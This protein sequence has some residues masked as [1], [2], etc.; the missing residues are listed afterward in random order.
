MFI[1]AKL[2][3]SQLVNIV[4]GTVCAVAILCALMLKLVSTIRNRKLDA[5]ADRKY[6]EW[7]ADVEANGGKLPVRTPPIR[8]D[9]GETCRFM[10][11]TARLYEPRA[12]SSGRYGGGSIHIDQGVSIHTGRITTESH[13]E[14]RVT[15]RGALYVTDKRIIFNG[16]IADHIVPLRDILSVRAGYRDACVHL[17]TSSK[18]VAFGSI[19]GQIFAAVVNSLC[20]SN[21]QVPGA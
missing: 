13:D 21:E 18:P 8:L 17:Q 14:W 4:G 3:D 16:E 19:N 20:S 2:T 10:D 15:T 1:L 12:I 7:L 9:A 5:A 6:R 11:L